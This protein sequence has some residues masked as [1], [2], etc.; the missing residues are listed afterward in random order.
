MAARSAYDET[1]SRTVVNTRSTSWPSAAASHTLR[2][3]ELRRPMPSR[4]TLTTSSMTADATSCSR[5]RRSAPPRLLPRPHVPRRRSSAASR[6]PCAS[7]AWRVPRWSRRSS[8]QALHPPPTR[9]ALGCGGGLRTC[10][11]RSTTPR[12]PR[13]RRGRSLPARL[14][15]RQAIG[16]ARFRAERMGGAAEAYAGRAPLRA[17]VARSGWRHAEIS[18][19]TPGR[20]SWNASPARRRE[21]RRG[22]RCRRAQ[23]AQAT[24]TVGERGGRRG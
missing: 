16:I 10:L 7:S 9:G 15:A 12:P 3:C 13:L 21:R 18:I 20:A 6:R 17:A 19:D 4:A 24:R 1:R 23:R 2:P 11:R 5:R 22:T 8:M 14:P